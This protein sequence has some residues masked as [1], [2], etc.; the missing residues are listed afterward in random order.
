MKQG[1]VE[2]IRASNGWIKS[3]HVKAK[4]APKERENTGD[5]GRSQFN[6]PEIW[7]ACR[8]AGLEQ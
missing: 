2:S 3:Y 8:N 6:R 1:G 5:E 7:P 4:A